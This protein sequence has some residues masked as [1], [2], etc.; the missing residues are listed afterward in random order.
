MR[1]MHTFVPQGK[2]PV[3]AYGLLEF[4]CSD[5]DR[6][7]TPILVEFFRGFDLV[8]ERSHPR[9]VIFANRIRWG[10]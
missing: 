6:S 7:L 5:P 10:Q 8:A 3:G 9:Q 4:Y 2:L 1:V